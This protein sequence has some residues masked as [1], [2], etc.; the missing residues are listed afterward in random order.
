M[1]IESSIWPLSVNE[2]GGSC[3]KKCKLFTLCD[4]YNYVRLHAATGLPRDVGYI[5]QPLRLRRLRRNTELVIAATHPYEAVHKEHVA[6]HLGGG[7]LPQY[8]T[9]SRYIV[10]RRH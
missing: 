5:L 2:P 7:R 1:G 8:K 4:S 9:Y 3:E 10:I 6:L